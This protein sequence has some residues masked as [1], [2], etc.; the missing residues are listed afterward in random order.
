MEAKILKQEENLFLKRVEYTVE[1][2]SKSNPCEEDIK[3]FL[4]KD[5]ELTIVRTISSNFG[6]NSF[7]A[8]VVVYDS[9]EAKEQVVTIPKK[10]RKQMEE[11]R[12]K[13]EAAKKKEEE[14]AKAAEEAAKKAEEEAKAAE[15]EKPEVEATE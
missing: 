1:V 2:K 9:A 6:K 10:V 4:G 13:A 15:S 11:D 5:V 8:D 14:A 12:K 7:L 3:K